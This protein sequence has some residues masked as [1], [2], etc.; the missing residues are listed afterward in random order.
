M[1]QLLLG[2]LKIPSSAMFHNTL[3]KFVACGW[4]RMASISM[5]RLTISTIITTIGIN[6]IA[7]RSDV[8]ASVALLFKTTC[9][10][11]ALCILEGLCSW[12]DQAHFA[13]RSVCK[14]NATQQ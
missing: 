11:K 8:Y 3:M 9:E 14:S 10:K 6:I 7:K 12:T 5:I 13:Q 1:M 2:N 4:W